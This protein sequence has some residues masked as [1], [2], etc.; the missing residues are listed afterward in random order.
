LTFTPSS[1]RTSDFDGSLGVTAPMM[2]VPMRTND[3]RSRRAAAR[4]MFTFS[5]W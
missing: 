2:S 3:R 4:P 5:F 1:G